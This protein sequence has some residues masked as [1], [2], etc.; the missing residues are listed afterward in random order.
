MIR[1]AL[2]L[3]TNISVMIG[4]GLMVSLIGIKLKTVSTIIL[5]A[6]V[7][8]FS[9]AVISLFLSKQIAVSSVK[10]KYIDKPKDELESWLINIIRNQA[11]HIGIVMPKVA[12]YPAEDMN[13]FATGAT[14]NNSVVAVS[15]GLLNNMKKEQIEA[16]LAHEM[17]H[18]GNGDM[19][20]MTLLQGIVNTMVI[21]MVRILSQI[22]S[23]L[24]SSNHR[25]S[26]TN[27]ENT[28]IYSMIIRILQGVLGVLASLITMWFS[29]RREFY[30]DAGAAKMVGAE[31]MISALQRLKSS[32]EPKENNLVRAFCIHG[33]NTTNTKISYPRTDLFKTHPSLEKRIIALR[34]KQYL[35]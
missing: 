6:G 34:T 33:S 26:K 10:G 5:L 22:T 12:I 14:R 18:I 7:G 27:S 30:A 4:L 11:K 8:G 29:R 25:I 15:T 21:L 9:G 13:A 28:M 23:V 2:F 19:V 16:V 24:S 35:K 17:S 31:K 1:M 20:T 32:C 3:I